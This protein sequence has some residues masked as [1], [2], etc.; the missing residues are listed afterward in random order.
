MFM[1]LE[2]V[3]DFLAEDFINKKITYPEFLK[4]ANEISNYMQKMRNKNC[5]KKPSLYR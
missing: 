3:P 4:R 2:L 5:L 1:D